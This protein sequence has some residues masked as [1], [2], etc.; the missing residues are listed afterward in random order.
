MSTKT[1][2]GFGSGKPWLLREFSFFYKDNANETLLIPQGMPVNPDLHAHYWK[3]VETF[4]GMFDAGLKPS[5]YGVYQHGE[6]VATGNINKAD[7]PHEM[8]WFACMFVERGIGNMRWAFDP[9]SENH[10][11]MASVKGTV[12]IHAPEVPH[13]G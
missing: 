13:H 12:K 6:L 5:L 1:P 2:L 3:L 8:A 7:G 10:A 9:T 4:S 11:K